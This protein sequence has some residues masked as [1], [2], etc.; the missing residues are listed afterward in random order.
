MGA[1]KANEINHKET[2]FIQT[3]KNAVLPYNQLHYS[4]TNSNLV[5]LQFKSSM[6]NRKSEKKRDATNR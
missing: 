2:W 3:R 6:Q 1:D 5:K 4:S